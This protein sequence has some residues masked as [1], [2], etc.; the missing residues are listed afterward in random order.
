MVTSAKNDIKSLVERMIGGEEG[1]R[2]RSILAP[3]VRGGRIAARVGGL[4]HAFRLD[5]PAFE[6]WGIFRPVDFSRARLE[7]TAPPARIEAY[8]AALEPRRL[9]LV[10]K[11]GGKTWLGWLAG[12]AD[13]RGRPAQ[14]RPVPVHLVDGAERFD[15][16]RARR[17]GRSLWF[18]AV[19]RGA[20]PRIAAGLRRSL[21]EGIDAGSLRVR[22][23]T[24]DLREA[25]AIAAGE[26][27]ESRRRGEEA[28]IRDVLE[29]FGGRLEDVRE[30]ES[31]RIVTWRGADGWL[32]H[33]LVRGEDLTVVSAGICLDGRDEEFDLASLSSV[34]EEYERNER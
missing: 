22:D 20:D 4:V 15:V 17:D 24:P 8:L 27:R 33:S 25:Y 18:E 2:K 14:E 16:V 6:G 30:G 7:G 9:V 12:A 32:R 28:R 29:R 5:G 26:V 13:R 23:L 21:S 11:L 3:A 31:G 10:R 19:D 34:F 1:L